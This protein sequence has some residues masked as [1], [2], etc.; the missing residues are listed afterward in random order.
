MQ[1]SGAVISPPVT[2]DDND[3]DGAATILEAGAGSLPVVGLQHAGLSG[4]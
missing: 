4:R 2:K 1:D 3:M